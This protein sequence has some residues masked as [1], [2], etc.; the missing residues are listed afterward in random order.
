[1]KSKIWI[2]VV[3]TIVLTA[4]GWMYFH[5]SG[6]NPRSAQQSVLASELSKAT[7]QFIEYKEDATGQQVLSTDFEKIRQNAIA[8]L[9]PHNDPDYSKRLSL[10]AVGKRYVLVGMPGPEEN[11]PTIFDS[12]TSKSVPISGLY[13]FTVGNTQVYVSTTDICTYTLDTDACA[14][15]PGAKLSGNEIYGD[16]SG[17]GGYFVPQDFTHTGTSLTLAV[18]AWSAP[19]TDKAKLQKV[20]SLTLPLYLPTGR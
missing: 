3:A 14:P 20:R 7:P 18:L 9:L 12:I 8:I 11:H 1:M 5:G 2:C 6:V 15:I 10:I 16:D 19:G 17:L 13:Q 4:G